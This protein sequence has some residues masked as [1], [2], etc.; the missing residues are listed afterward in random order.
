MESIQDFLKPDNIQQFLS[1]NPAIY[2][3][4]LFLFGLFL[5]LAALF[6]CNWIFGNTNSH[7][8][9]TSKNGGT[10]IGF[11]RKTARV[12]VGFLGLVIML[13]IVLVIGLSK[14]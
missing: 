8:Y 5:F 9:N 14:D 12:L 6:N 2:Y 7:N 4:I 11:G 1:D 13:C 3:V 10:I